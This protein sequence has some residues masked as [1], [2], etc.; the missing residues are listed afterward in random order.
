MITVITPTGDRPEAFKLCRK[1]IAHQTVNPDQWLIV[2]D[3]KEPLKFAPVG[4]EKY[5]RREPQPTDPKHTLTV[6]VAEALKYVTGDKILFMEDDEYYAPTYIEEMSMRLERFQVVGIGWAKYYHLPTGGYVEHKNMN[7]ASLAQTGY[8]KEV[9]GLIKKCV[10]RG[11]EKEW[12]DCQIWAE[13]MKTQGSLNKIPCNIF[14]DIDNP[15]Y[16]GMKGLPGR[17]GIGI[18]HKETM[19]SSHDDANR[20]KL[21]EWIRKVDDFQLYMSLLNGETV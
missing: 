21:R 2:D 7:H 18:G 19:Y 12:L 6:N 11:M 4:Y 3:G 14:R 1:W 20:T 9:S 15:L 16:V 10:A 8:R 17:N 13:T 5:I